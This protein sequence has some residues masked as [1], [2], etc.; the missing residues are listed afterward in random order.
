MWYKFW[1]KSSR[2]TNTWAYRYLTKKDI[3]DQSLQSRVE[4][5]ADGFGAMHVSENLIHYGYEKVKMG[6]KAQIDK[7]IHDLNVR[8]HRLEHEAARLRAES[9]RLCDV[10]SFLNHLKFDKAK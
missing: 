1:I 6:T 4:Q 7:R 10:R 3:K 8:C 5:W 2:G 9:V